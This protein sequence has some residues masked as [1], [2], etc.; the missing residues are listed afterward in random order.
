[1]SDTTKSYSVKNSHPFS[2]R[3]DVN[4]VHNLEAV[5]EKIGAI[6]YRSRGILTLV[7]NHLLDHGDSEASHITAAIEAVI[8]EIKDLEEINRLFDSAMKTNSDVMGGGQ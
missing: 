5:S 6:G 1:M 7:L 3:F 8:D 4:N 2:H